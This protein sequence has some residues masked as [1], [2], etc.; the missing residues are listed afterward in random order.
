MGFGCSCPIRVKEDENSEHKNSKSRTSL[1]KRSYSSTSKLHMSAYYSYEYHNTKY[2]NSNFII[3]TNIDNFQNEFYVID[4]N[5]KSSVT[6]S[7]YK[8]SGIAIGYN[9]GYKLD[10]QNQDKFFILLDGEVE[11]YCVIDG[12]GPFGNVIAQIIQDK[13]FKELIET[14]FNENFD[15]EYERILKN[16]FETTQNLIIK[17][18]GKFKD[19]Y[20]P[21]LS[22]ACVTLVVKKDNHLYCANVGNV[23]AFL[24]Y[25]ERVYSYSKTKVLVT[26][27]SNFKV[28]G[29]T[30]QVVANLH[31]MNHASKV[32]YNVAESNL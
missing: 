5:N 10:V 15:S 12:H 29:S 28:D 27:D 9:K 13:F 8:S 24:M 22:G 2:A 19:D 7:L 20:D 18:E 11:I 31:N 23:L 4:E 3:Y 30:H 17:K 26:D 32:Y 16:L 25:C 21:Y 6:S 14:V 1:N